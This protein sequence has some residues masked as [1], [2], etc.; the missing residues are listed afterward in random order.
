VERV[1]QLWRERDG[2]DGINSRTV[3]L[4]LKDDASE[5]EEARRCFEGLVEH[6]DLLI[7]PYGSPMTRAVLPAVEA[8]GRPCLI[9]SAGD[10]GIWAERRDWLLQLL[11]PSDTMLH[12]AI[13]LAADHGLGSAA[14]IRRK[15]PLSRLVVAG[16]AKRAG[17][18]GLERRMR[19]PTAMPRP[20]RRAVALAFVKPP[21]LPWRAR[22]SAT[23]SEGPLR[24]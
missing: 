24:R 4:A 10:R 15:N 16:A 6:A 5:P 23:S 3:E 1:L 9:P 17:E 20:V 7:A 21:R 12:N 11:N 22:T 8:A 14:F 18:R 19:Q 13:A 2:L